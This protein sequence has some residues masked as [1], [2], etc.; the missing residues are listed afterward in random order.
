MSSISSLK[1]ESPTFSGYEINNR[2]FAIFLKPLEYD[3]DMKLN[4]TGFNVVFCTN[5]TARRSINITAD[6]FYFVG[7]NLSANSS[8]K[9]T[10]SRKLFFIGG[11][12]NSEKKE[13]IASGGKVE[14]NADTKRI[15]YIR[16]LFVE[17]IQNSKPQDFLTTLFEV[18]YAIEDPFEERSNLGK[19]LNECLEFL[20]IPLVL[21][22]DQN[23][24]LLNVLE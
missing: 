7:A 8:I 21:P 23:P 20:E 24:D 22:A 19:T 4:L 15:I 3:Q 13:I 5:I 1:F 14:V 6:S 17:A 16:K 18:I 11:S 10:S 9:I 12:L 2:P